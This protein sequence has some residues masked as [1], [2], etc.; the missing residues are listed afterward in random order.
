MFN[1]LRHFSLTSA[2]A[3]LVATALLVGV[4]RHTVVAGDVERAETENAR[5]ATSFSNTFF[6]HLSPRMTTMGAAG[7]EALRDA[8]L[9]ALDIVLRSMTE[10]LPV[11]KV[12]IYDL[13][14]HVIYSPARSEL[15]EP[16]HAP[17]S[18]AAALA[19]RT[20]SYQAFKPRIATWTGLLTDRHVV[21]T[22]TPLVNGTG[23]VVGAFELTSDITAQTGM[24]QATSLRL[25]AIIV[26]TF[27]I[28]YGALLLVVRRADRI[29]RHQQRQIEDSRAELRAIADYTFDWESWIDRDGRPRWINPA[30]ERV[31]GYSVARCMAMTDYPLPIVHADD[32]AHVATLRERAAAGDFASDEEFRVICGNGATIWVTANFQPI[33]DAAGAPIGARWSIHDITARKRAEAALQ[34]QQEMFHLLLDA[35][36]EGIYGIDL[37]GR[38]TFVNQAAARMTGWTAEALLGNGIHDIIHHTRGDGTPFPAC[39]CPVHETLT[40]GVARDVSGDIFWRR[41]GT[42]FPV[43]FVASPIRKSGALAGVVTVFRDVTAHL[44]WI[45]TLRHEREFSR[46]VIDS[47]PG[48]FYLI[49]ADGRFKLWNRNFEV[50][51]GYDAAEIGGLH[52]LDLFEGDDKATIAAAMAEVFGTGAATAEAYL[53]TK[54]GDRLPYYF[55]GQRL[56]SEGN[57]ELIGMAVDISGH[58]KLE[59]ALRRSN[60]ELEAFA[61]VASHD[62]QEPLRMV[63][64]YMQLLKSRYR[65]RLDADAE[66][67]IGFAVDGAMRMERLIKDLLAYSRL[68]RHGRTF[69]PVALGPV[70]EAAL[71]DL[72]A[73]IADSGAEVACEPLPVVDGD[74]TQLVR[75]FQNLIGNAVK[76]H[77]PAVA[78]RIRIAATPHGNAWQ[79]AVEDNGIGI[80]PEHYDR[81]F[82]IFQRLHR[83][84][85]YGGT[86]IGLAECK[87]IVESHGGRIWI[88]PGAEGSRFLFTLP[89]ASQS[90]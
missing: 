42:S 72:R 77:R 83:R 34:E 8:E 74:T 6:R 43:E 55:S 60:Q 88:E 86:G 9:R 22:Y 38:V 67:F 46:S 36:G 65:G 63:T 49:A 2:G 56:V 20:A 84:G 69:A 61:Y 5:L 29:L 71:G 53:I 19:G 90:L 12:K 11:M 68:S 37:N 82:V 47:L 85:E 24:L 78:P 15:G 3:M 75:L 23:G 7:H 45:D 54:G 70:V 58:K 48:I 73:A 76:Y 32:Q 16:S 57:A 21:S 18:L 41:D 31:A 14:G 80:A 44:Q 28:L 4:F 40:R 50:V 33:Y 25:A 27:A 66:E 35:V 10:T 59:D 81:V 30:V 26:A 89:A 79:I 17:D 13:G 52:A 39:E 87:K 64:S 62:L 1:L 51:T